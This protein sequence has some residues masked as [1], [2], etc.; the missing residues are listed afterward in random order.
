MRA[1]PLLFGLWVFVA[2]TMVGTVTQ[3]DVDYQEVLFRLYQRYAHYARIQDMLDIFSEGRPSAPSGGQARIVAS[4]GSAAHP[5]GGAPVAELLPPRD[6][7][8]DASPPHTLTVL[9][10]GS[11]GQDFWAD[12]RLSDPVH[13]VQ[14]SYQ[15]ELSA[16]TVQLPGNWTI[17]GEKK[18]YTLSHPLVARFAV[19]EA[20]PDTRLRFYA[21]KRAQITDSEPEVLIN[22]THMHVTIK[23]KGREGAAKQGSPARPPAKGT[24]AP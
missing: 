3:G 21:R 18:K 15:K 10:F 11:R 19:L 17:R 2:S 16:W 5:S 14:V 7:T 23:A 22:G 4:Q 8:P 12:F 13:T 1:H 20:S 24:V 9:G 6:G